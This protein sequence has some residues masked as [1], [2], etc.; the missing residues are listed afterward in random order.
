MEGK[1][2]ATV[3]LNRRGQSLVDKA[4]ITEART[5]GRNQLG[6]P[7]RRKG[8]ITRVN[9]ILASNLRKK[10]SYKE[11]TK[12][13]NFQIFRPKSCTETNRTAPKMVLI[14]IVQTILRH[15]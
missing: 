2:I 1:K 12:A 3:R 11:K 15:L 8:T 13:K 5:T 10:L 9:K 7:T 14:I 6:H 4:K